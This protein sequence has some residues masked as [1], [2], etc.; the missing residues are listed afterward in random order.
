M[1]IKYTIK[2]ETGC[3]IWE[4]AIRGKC[5]YGAIKHKGVVWSAHRLAY[6]FKHGSIP[7]RKMVSHRCKDKL[8]VNPDHLFLATK[9]D[10]PQKKPKS[11]KKR[12]LSPINPLVA[13]T[14][15]ERKISLKMISI[16]FGI[17][18]GAVR[19][20]KSRLIA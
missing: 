17:S 3:W 13:A 19:H 8:C 16:R 18:Y 9:K 7:D 20:I 11:I 4:G 5:G 14:I 2:Q 1:A 12:A 6:V 15:M 10:L